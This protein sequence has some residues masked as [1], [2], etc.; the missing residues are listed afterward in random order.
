MS[1]TT[2]IDIQNF[3]QKYA[4]TSGSL[5]AGQNDIDPRKTISDIVAN[6]VRNVISM[7][8]FRSTGIH[9]TK[10]IWVFNQC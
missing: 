8:G 3:W 1:R 7:T 9:G 2:L 5:D 4:D 10:S 6:Y